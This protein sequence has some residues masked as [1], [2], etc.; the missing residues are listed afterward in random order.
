ML[1]LCLSAPF[2]LR[3]KAALAAEDSLT[4]THGLSRFGEL[5]YPEN[6]THFN[7]ANPDAPKGGTLSYLPA[8]WVLNQNPNTFNTL[9]SYVLGGDAPPLMELTF[10]TLMVRAFDEPDAVYP[11]LALKTR[12]NAERTVYEFMLD[13][14]A[15]FHDGTTLSADD[16]VFSF[17]TLRQDGHPMLSASLAQI[18]HCEAV[19]PQLV[20]V[21]LKKDAAPDLIFTLAT[22]MPIVSK[23]YYGKQKFNETSLQ[24]P[25]GSGGFKVA[26]LSPGR[27][28]EYQRVASWWGWSRP[29]LRGQFNFDKIRIE[30][31][32]DFDVAFEA[33][34]AGQYL[35]R[36]E[37]SSRLWAV[38]YDFPAVKTGAVKK[39]VTPDQRAAGMQ[40]FFINMRRDKFKD[41]RVR[42]AL[43]LAFDF[44]WANKNLFYGSYTRTASPFQNTPL[45]A[46][47]LPSPEEMA[48]LEPLR[49]RILPE[50]YGEAVV[51]P[52]SDASGADRR[53][54]GKAIRLMADAG[55]KR[56]QTA[57]FLQ[58]GSPFKIECLADNPSYEKFFMPF[59]RNLRAIGIDASLRMVDASQYQAR[60]NT[61]DFDIVSMRYGLS[62]TPGDDL[63]RVFSS[64]DA[65]RPGT[66]NLSG[67]KHPVVDEL[68]EKIIAA[69]DR[70]TMQT[71]CR[72]L[73]RILRTQ[74]F[75]VPA[76]YKPSH[77]I[78]Y[79]D[80]YDAPAQKPLY[81]DGVLQ[82]W[83][84]NRARAQQRGKGQ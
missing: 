10:A 21:T 64:A 37:F 70:Q 16:V 27:M 5:K 39:I 18:D 68:I 69:K 42:Q 83:W 26:S 77:T 19:S 6:F 31:Y 2:L 52:V 82:T 59:V 23:A 7:Y 28:I 1:S 80:V 60:L 76:W 8:Q 74:Y 53:L 72:V 48:I 44:E 55:I 54:L 15:V 66:Y 47:G 51:P 34:K 57:A 71:T 58:D 11:L 20:R 75:W 9:N 35:V 3:A 78:A 56:R 46:T 50:A 67:L 30:F 24:I 62:Q 40:G 33:F 45:M 17:E 41:P 49:N 13:P 38:A 12:H 81:A 36:E 65:D 14:A 32:R 73:D 79:W 22:D 25:L 63:R 43:G 61:Y 4:Q 84:L 29:A